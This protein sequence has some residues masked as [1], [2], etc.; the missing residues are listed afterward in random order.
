MYFLKTC[1]D[2]YIQ[3]LGEGPDE[4]RDNLGLVLGTEESEQDGVELSVG[5]HLV[6]A[7][8]DHEELL[9]DWSELDT[10]SELLDESARHTGQHIELESE[11][12]LADLL[13]QLDDFEHFSCSNDPMRVSKYFLLLSNCCSCL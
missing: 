2:K 7:V 9:D 3:Q 5:C 6:Q 12:L 10:A 4:L 13:L 1:G 11:L 8:S